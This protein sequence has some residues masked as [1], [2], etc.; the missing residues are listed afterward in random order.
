VGKERTSLLP[1]A[2]PLAQLLARPNAFSDFSSLIEMTVMH[3]LIHGEALWEIES[4]RLFAYPPSSIVRVNVAADNSDY[5]NFELSIS[6][7]NFKI[8]AEDAIF[9]KLP[10]PS[11]PW[12]GASPMSSAI[13]TATCDYNAQKFNAR[14]FDVA[15]A[16]AF[17]IRREGEAAGHLTPEDKL[18]LQAEIQ[19][20]QGGVDNSNGVLFLGPGEKIETIGLAPKEGSFTKLQDQARDRILSVFRVPPILL[21]NVDNAN[22]S[23]SEMQIQHFWRQVVCPLLE[24]IQAVL[25]HRLAPRFGSDVRLQFDYASVP[26]LQPDTSALMSWALPAIEHGVVLPNEIRVE[27]LDKP[28]VPWGDQWWHDA[29]TVAA[30]QEGTDADPLRSFNLDEKVVAEIREMFTV[31]AERDKAEGE[32]W[33][34]YREARK[35]M[36]RFSIPRP[37]ALCLARQFLTGAGRE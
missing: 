14:F 29:N 11:N 3:L 2:H 4:G 18:R 25:N 1:A 21:G 17:V 9:F 22:R 6:G 12:R 31:D 15:P 30:G 36:R 28:P 37:A 26:A 27:H 19:S 32:S 20:T 13:Q 23:N 35:A 34:I 10:D 16:P 5:L 7:K 24:D 8:P 33:D